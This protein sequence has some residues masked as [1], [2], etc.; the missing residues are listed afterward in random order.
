MRELLEQLNASLI[1]VV[2]KIE[3]KGHLINYFPEQ[4]IPETVVKATDILRT[5]STLKI[6]QSDH[7]AEVKVENLEFA[8]Y[9]LADLRYKSVLTPDELR[10]WER[11]SGD[12]PTAIAGKIQRGL[13]YITLTQD[14][15]VAQA[16][17]GSISHPAY[18]SG[19]FSVSF[20]TPYSISWSSSD[21]FINK[22]TEGIN[23][24]RS[25]GFGGKLRLFV[26]R[27]AFQR[28]ISDSTLS[29]LLTAQSIA[30][31]FI[32]GESNLLVLGVEIVP[33]FIEVDG[34][35]LVADNK[36]YLVSD[37]AIV[38]VYGLPNLINTQ[39]VKYQPVV[40]Y[41]EHDLQGAE[42]IVASR[43]LPV[44]FTQGIVKYNLT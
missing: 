17:T 20:G 44:A 23:R 33:A 29:T 27:E 2:R 16:F 15:L 34:A 36:A 37:D 13:A 28:I 1:E 7:P 14:K 3:I 9:P 42:I 26:G 40:V 19:V 22:L 25:K 11:I 12:L 10:A 30:G 8:V 18:P 21:N 5:F 6:A 35:P 43:Y 41:N 4:I 38:N 31:S 39:P 24:I 32:S